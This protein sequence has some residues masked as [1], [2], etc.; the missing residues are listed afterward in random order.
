M[1]IGVW[2]DLWQA[3][4]KASGWVFLLIQCSE[5]FSAANLKQHEPNFSV[6]LGSPMNT[7]RK[8]EEVQGTVRAAHFSKQNHEKNLILKKTKIRI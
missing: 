8:G 5:P 7:S 2:M 4:D 3:R 6:R 1:F